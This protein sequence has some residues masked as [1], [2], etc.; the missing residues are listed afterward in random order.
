[1]RLGYDLCQEEQ[2]FLHKRKRVVA[3]A[4][5]RVLH[6]ERDLHGHEVCE[7]E[8]KHGVWV[9]WIRIGTTPHQISGSFCML[10]TNPLICMAAQQKFSVWHTP[11]SS[12]ISAQLFT[13]PFFSMGQIPKDIVH[14]SSKPEFPT[15]WCSGSA[16]YKALVHCFMHSLARQPKP[17]RETGVFEIHLT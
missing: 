6:L 11:Y 1:M 17:S 3:S 16:R 15:V 10:M 14:H 12:K 4:L 5:K 9:Y 13:P 8:S 7:L 2:E